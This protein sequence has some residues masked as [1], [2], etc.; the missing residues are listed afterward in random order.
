MIQ[1]QI[2]YFEGLLVCVVGYCVCYI[3]D[4]CGFVVGG[5]YLVECCCRVISKYV[6]F[7]VVFV[8]WCCINC[9]VCSVCKILFVIDVLV[10]NVIQLCL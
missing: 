7:I 1:M 8:E 2:S 10:V 5:G 9:F 4:L 3:Y 6:E